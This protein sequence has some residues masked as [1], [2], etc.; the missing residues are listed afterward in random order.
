MKYLLVSDIHGSIDSSKILID[1]FINNHCDKIIILGDILYHGPRN[2]L[3]DSYLPKEVFK[4][5]NEYKDKIIAI[6]GNCDGEVDQ[7]VLNFK[8]FNKY[9]LKV[10]G[11]KILLTHGHKYN[12][13]SPIKDKT[14]DI[15]I[16]GHTHINSVNIV[17]N[18]KYI[19]IGSITLPKN[20]TARCY[21]I[22]DDKAIF[23]YDLNDKLIIKE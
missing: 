2:D 21:G 11:H 7:M 12:Y 17:D 20:N 1:K 5:L 10:N 16:H 23:I 13:L 9:T 8:L 6:K 15:V 19:N 3:P 4:L 22:I 18:V 14:Y